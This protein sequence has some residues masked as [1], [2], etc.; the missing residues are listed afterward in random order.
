MRWIAFAIIVYIVAVLQTAV[1][2]FLKLHG[3]WPDLMVISAVYFALVAKPV[4][5]RMACWVVGLTADLL[6][7][8]YD[9]YSN[10]GIRAVSFGLAAIVIVKVR[11]FFFRE[12]VWSQLF[13]TFGAKLFVDVAVGLHMLYVLGQMDRFGAILTTAIYQAVYTAALAPYGHW[14]LRQ[15]RGPLG[16]GTAPRWT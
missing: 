13:F 7:L 1:A 2:P 4:D 12:S 9:G 10:V 5:A 11:D 8:S 3:V 16:V 15:L 14:L 6:T